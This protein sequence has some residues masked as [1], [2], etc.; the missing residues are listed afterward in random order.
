MNTCYQLR[1]WRACRRRISRSLLDRFEVVQLVGLE[2]G[3][4]FV[5]TFETENQF[6]VRK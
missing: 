4:N 5:E 3:M 6:K 1:N 2:L